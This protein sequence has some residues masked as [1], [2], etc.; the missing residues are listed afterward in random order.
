M[1]E[2]ICN[3]CGSKL[4]IWDTQEN[5]SLWR[6]LGY[7]TKYDGD[8]LKL[9]LCCKCMEEIIDSCLISPIIEKD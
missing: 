5:F 2:E 7:G 8:T 1:T 4:D 3:R 9:K 6:S